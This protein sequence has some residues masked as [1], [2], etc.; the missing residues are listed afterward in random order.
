MPRNTRK[1]LVGKREENYQI[2]L[3]AEK[4]A[5][6]EQSLHRTLRWCDCSLISRWNATSC[7]RN[8]K[9]TCRTNPKE[10]D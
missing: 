9:C 6:L 4:L 2:Y 1:E 8:G 3:R 7:C 10:A 5:E